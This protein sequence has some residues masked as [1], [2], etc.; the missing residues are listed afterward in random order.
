MPSPS[1]TPANSLATPIE[2]GFTVDA[3]AP[4]VALAKA[5]AGGDER[6]FQRPGASATE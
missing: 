6:A 3:I 2:K 1:P 5:G 4:T